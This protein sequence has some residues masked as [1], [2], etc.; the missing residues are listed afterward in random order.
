MN[1]GVTWIKTYLD[2]YMAHAATVAVRALP[3]LTVTNEVGERG[4]SQQLTWR[5]AIDQSPRLLVVGAAGA[6][7]SCSLRLQA[8]TM[9]NAVLNEQRTAKSKNMPHVP[10]Y[11]DL[12]Q[13]RDS[14]EQTIGES[15][16]VSVPVWRELSER[17]LVF[18]IDGLEQLRSDIQLTALSSIATLMSMLGTQA[19]WVLTCRSE[20]LPLFRPWFGTA[21]VRVLRPLPPREVVTYVRTQCGDAAAQLLEADDVAVALAGRPRWLGAYIQ[22]MSREQASSRQLR[23]Q[24]LWEWMQGVV[25]MTDTTAPDALA[26]LLRIRNDMGGQRDPWVLADV[27]QRALPGVVNTALVAQQLLGAPTTD[28]II[29]AM[30]ALVGAGV[31]LFDY[32]QQTLTFRH[33]LL[34]AVVS[35]M[36]LLTQPV[37]SW[38]LAQLTEDDEIVGLVFA[39]NENRPAVVRRC[40]ELGLVRAV[41]RAL[42]H[43]DSARVEEVLQAA[44]VHTA[45]LRLAVA[46]IL[47]QEGAYRQ[48]RQQLEFVSVMQPQ[49]TDVLRRIA[50]LSTML[51]D[52]PGAVKSYEIISKTRPEDLHSRHQLGVAY[53]KLGSLDAAAHVLRGLFDTYRQQGANVARALGQIYSQQKNHPAA[54]EAFDLALRDVTDDP[55]LYRNK[56]QV[57]EQLDRASEAQVLLVNAVARLGD[58]PALL[59][60]LGRLC[61][62]RG[63]LP[64]AQNYLDK[65]IN[66]APDDAVSHATLGRVYLS[67]ADWHGAWSAL[68]RAIELQ[69]SDDTLYVDFAHVCDAS[70]DSD[71]AVVAL[72]TAI[73]L[74]PTN[75]AAYRHLMQ[76]LQRR[77]DVDGALQMVRTALGQA[78]NHAALHGDLA[79][80]LW[81]RGDHDNA[82][83][84]YRKAVTLAPNDTTYMH[85]MAQSLS[86]LGRQREAVEMYNKALGIDVDNVALLRDA[87]MAYEKL[88]QFEQGDAVLQRALLHRAD[89]PEL[90][91]I[92]AGFALRRG[93]IKRARGYVAKA[94]WS[95]RGDD[96]SWLHAGLLH[97]A[98]GHWKQALFALQRI[99][100]A[101][102]NSTVLEALGRALAGDGQ[103]EAAIRTFDQA[104][105]LQPENPQILVAYSQAMA[106]HGRFEQA[107]EHA[108]RAYQHDPGNVDAL[109]Q[110][111]RMALVTQRPNEASEMLEVAATLAPQRVDVQSERSRVLQSQGLFEQALHAARQALALDGQA[112][113]AVVVTAE[114]LFGLTRHEEARELYRQALIIDPNHEL[115]LS[116]LRDVSIVLG[117]FIQAAD[118]AQ[119]LVGLVP[120][121]A[122]HHLRLGEVLIAIGVCE[123]AIIELQQ[124][125]DIDRASPH[126][127]NSNATPVMDAVIYARMSAAYAKSTRWS[128]AR[129]CA[130][131]AVVAAPACAEH[132]ALLGDAFLGL[133]QRAS[134]IAS[135]R[136]ATQQR[137]DHAGWRYLLG[138]L[139]HHTGADKEAVQVL[140]EAVALSDRAEYYHTLGQAFLGV[141]DSKNAV[142]AIEKALAKRPEA[143]HWRADLA[144]VQAQRGWHKEAISEIDQALAVAADH[145]VL[146]RKRAEL[147]LRIN[148]IDAAAA[149]VLEA[150]RR[151]AHD[152]KALTLMS[153][154]MQRKGNLQRACEAAERATKLNANDAYARYQLATV[155]RVLKR[156]G[157]AIPHMIAAVRLR[158]QDAE[159]WVELC[160]DYESINDFVTAAQC[161]ARAVE[162][163][164]MELNLV[165]RLGMLY[166]QSGAYTEAER[167]LRRVMAQLPSA[168]ATIA[169]LADVSLAQGKND[170]ALSLARRAIELQGQVS[171]H[172][173][174]F[175]RVLRTLERYDEALE[176]ARTGFQLDNEHAPSALMYGI[177]LLDFA[178][179]EQAVTAFAAAVK[180]DD[181][182]AIYQ[183]CLGMALRQQAPLA[184]DLEEFTQPTPMHLV[185][186]TAAMQ[187]FDRTLTIE[188]DNPRCIF[189]RGV[190][191]QLML[192]HHEAIASFDAALALYGEVHPRPLSGDA[193][194]ASMLDKSDLAAHIRQR[195]ALS[196]ALLHQYEAAL[197][198]Q[199]YVLA[200]APLS[201]Q[202]QYIY[203]RLA[204]LTGDLDGALSALASTATSMPGNATV[205][206]WYGTVLFAHGR[207]KEAVM[208][209]EL[210][211]DLLPS[212]GT[213]NGLLRDVYTADKRIDRAIGAAQ[214]ATRYDSANPDNHY[215]LAKLYMQ[216]HRNGDARAAVMV[217]ITLKNDIIEWHMLL[218]D[219]C[220]QM[221]MFDNSRSAYL[222]ATSLDPESTAPLY[223]LSRLLVLQGRINDAIT[224]LEQALLRD[225]QNGAWYFELGQLYEQR[226]DQDMARAAYNKAILLDG[227]KAEYYRAVSKIEAKQHAKTKEPPQV[228]TATE[229]VKRHAHK[230]AN[231]AEMFLAMGDVNFEQKLYDTALEHYQS[232]LA[233]DMTYAPSWCRVAQTKVKLGRVKDAQNDFH[234]AL[235]HDAKCVDAHGGLAA[236]AHKERR[237][238]DALEH[239]RLAVAIDPNGVTY[240]LDLAETLYALNQKEECQQTLRKMIKYLPSDPI[241]LVSFA[242]LAMK[243]AM[244]D[245]AFTALQ[246]AINIDDTNDRAYL[247]IGRIYRQKSATQ[248]AV[249]AF[250]RAV[251]LNPN[252]KEAQY[253]LTFVAPLS[254]FTRRRDVD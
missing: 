53:G 81:R 231:E 96:Q 154:I 250:R 243:V 85:A 169:C 152:V 92:A 51:H 14:V 38:S 171:E 252:N 205:Q 111:G 89:N 146:W 21:D 217:A 56:A 202:D 109:L 196:L 126:P 105:Q 236:I 70:G 156:R 153:Q 162:L 60:E 72:R 165:Y 108:R 167:Q 23:G 127:K 9:A 234:Q 32:E 131:Q 190:A 143:H 159:W 177:L 246:R 137:P 93:Q 121:S 161:M 133:G 160:A 39:I 47:Q 12:A 188:G 29:G 1:N 120:K 10:I 194:A 237:F 175:A 91:R 130:E 219:V 13:F 176:A 37:A 233:N 124:A 107:Y 215:Q 45:V 173:R 174:V 229:V 66:L 206:Q 200:V 191:L 149:D 88:G 180:A 44:G 27:A 244:T 218:G 63:E 99:V 247:L 179:I 64:A 213:I 224:N 214:R 118:V 55:L 46:D 209:L 6:G 193:V 101:V 84:T 183:L 98:E 207:L 119:R 110:V 25:T 17:S 181:G 42:L 195:R 77:G 76:L 199:R 172:W 18:F 68:Q 65:A 97:I 7:K 106:Q 79:G 82:L 43:H 100:D 114:A 67:L 144:D 80:L 54:L 226:G 210:A 129:E 11:V 182:V 102:S 2:A 57:L 166:F 134:A 185:K 125:L 19:R 22:L 113:E 148:Q 94:L 136:I 83:V 61:W 186:L 163:V 140:Q 104:I 4:R 141:G 135:Y 95:A 189:E 24:L 48:A 240:Q 5:Q 116:G 235:R 178:E 112:V 197:I 201:A 228:A 8:L 71:A 15:V 239:L 74:A 254:V 204:Y 16:G 164:P 86:E 49:D 168:A 34:R 253:E 26:R 78:G 187:A 220:A 158:D 69:P 40:I 208:A 241:L 147:L 242:E 184:K 103:I 245:D 35:A 203:G 138:M 59:A 142:S 198:D 238:A 87:V 192:R 52:W 211:N 33:N 30:R 251:K 75:V 58:Q 117:E 62:L 31:L 3:P 115:A 132:H 20:A 90:L 28:P 151:D 232:A 222:S 41:V 225:P 128:E 212:N 248:N 221:G 123:A 122:M 230:F 227:D 139:L 150:L 216:T 157:E 155:L 223:A 249:A 145:P 73:T 170:E 50:D 36:Q